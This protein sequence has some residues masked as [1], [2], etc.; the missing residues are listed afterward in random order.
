MLEND[1]KVILVTSTVSGEGK[2]FISSTLAISLSLLGKKEMRIRDRDVAR[3]FLF[4]V[5]L[6]LCR[7]LLAD[8][9][10]DLSLIHI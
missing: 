6:G 2:S 10:M 4:F 9:V 5:S 1:Q 7:Y 3:G 8:L